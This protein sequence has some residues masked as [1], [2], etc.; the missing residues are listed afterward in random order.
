MKNVMTICVLAVLTLSLSSC[1]IWD[2]FFGGKPTCDTTEKY[3]NIAGKQVASFLDCKNPAAISASLNASI[4]NLG[5]CKNPVEA[6]TISAIICRPVAMYVS[7]L[8][9]NGLPKEWECSG[10]AGARAV[11]TAVYAA[12]VLIPY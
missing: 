10:G 12:C 7:K 4:D 11:E 3:A 8:A 6:G 1:T 5:L 9:V 2:K